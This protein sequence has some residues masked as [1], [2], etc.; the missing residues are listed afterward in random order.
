[1]GHASRPPV[2][3]LVVWSALIPV[4]P[5]FVANLIPACL[6]VTAGRFAWTTL[7]GIIPGTLVFTWVGAGLGAVFARGESPDLG[8]IFDP[9]ILGPMLGLA[10][11]SLLPVV[12]KAVRRG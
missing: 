3:S 10:A 11:L 5:F 9:H 4:V 2:M 8:I 12:I 7:I 6:G 1:M